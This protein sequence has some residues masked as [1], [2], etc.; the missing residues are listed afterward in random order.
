MH[1][2][3]SCSTLQLAPGD[4]TRQV[5]LV[6]KA[7]RPQA[8]LH[9]WFFL[10]DICSQWVNLLVVD[11]GFLNADEGLVWGDLLRQ[12]HELHTIMEVMVPGGRGGGKSTW[13]MPAAWEQW[14]EAE[15]EARISTGTEKLQKEVFR[16]KRWLVMALGSLSEK[17]LSSSLIPGVQGEAGLHSFPWKKRSTSPPALTPARHSSSHQPNRERKEGGGKKKVLSP[18]FGEPLQPKKK[19]E[20][21]SGYSENHCLNCG[22]VQT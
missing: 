22:W 3:M 4:G 2:A 18:K 6:S 20:S 8:V 1:C 16:A 7:C 14:R 9:S 5:L 21:L 15:D 19:V 17:S 12:D 13:S 11:K 10:V